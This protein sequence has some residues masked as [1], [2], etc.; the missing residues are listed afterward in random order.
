MTER[1]RRKLSRQTKGH[2]FDIRRNSAISN[3]KWEYDNN[4]LLGAV[5]SMKMA[6]GVMQL[7]RKD[8]PGAR[9]AWGRYSVSRS[10]WP[11]L[12]HQLESNR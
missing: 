5:A 3:L 6:F 1:A 9:S 8:D 12:A 10:Q 4:A 2:I 7:A 11:H